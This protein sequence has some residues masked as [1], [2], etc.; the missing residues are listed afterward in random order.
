MALGEI[1]VAWGFSEEALAGVIHSERLLGTG[2]AQRSEGSVG[3]LQVTA[4]ELFHFLSTD[5]VEL[6]VAHAVRYH[7]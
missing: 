6:R 7:R 3:R 4:D 5:S 2:G 1:T